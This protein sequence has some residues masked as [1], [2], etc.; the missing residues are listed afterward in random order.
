MNK[1][2]AGIIAYTGFAYEMMDKADELCDRKMTEGPH[3]DLTIEINIEMENLKELA[4]K[5]VKE[6]GGKVI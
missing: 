1:T 5:A 4:E 3:R 2:E 6:F